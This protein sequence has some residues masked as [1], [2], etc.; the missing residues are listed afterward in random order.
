L[1]SSVSLRAN[2]IQSSKTSL[3][4]G[5]PSLIFDL[6]TFAR[7]VASLSTTVYADHQ[8]KKVNFSREVRLDESVINAACTDITYLSGF[9]LCHPFS[10]R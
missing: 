8:G 3:V 6:T 4:C 2:F 7:A 10:Q 9:V 5:T 1:I